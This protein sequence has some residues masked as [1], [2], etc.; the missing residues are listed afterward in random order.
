[1]EPHDF[2]AR[3]EEIKRR[4]SGRWSEL[5]RSLGVSDAILNRRNGP[6][7][8]C[9]GE[10]RFQYTD[11]FGQGDYYCRGCGHGDGF[12]LLRHVFGWDFVTAYRHV[13][14]LV[15]GQSSALVARPTEPSSDRMK[16]LARR[17]WQEA[18]P[19]KAGDEVDRYLTGRGLQFAD[20]PRTLRCH[21]ALAYYEKD[22][23]GKSRK[24]GECPAMLACIQGSDGHGIT[25]H[26]T[27]LRDGHKAFG[28]S[29]KRVL[30]AGIN[31]AAVRL[32][33]AT[34]E[35][36]ITEGIET[37]LAVH[38][39]TGKPVWSA[40]AAG[41][42]ERLWLPETVRRVCVYADND[43]D[44]DFDGQACAFALARRLKKEQKRTGA[45]QVSVFVPKVSGNDWADVWCARSRDV[46]QAA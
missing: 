37:A 10:D 33:A 15:G 32:F 16:L 11:K 14:S 30:S 41:N 25:L 8:G 5:L 46:D 6:C 35:L 19:V 17:L 45:R 24:V 21:P 7:P 26:R 20:Y 4:A 13:E 44:A 23:A 38:L 39:S 43:A 12:A 42:L 27:Y 18:E 36:A 3:V 9:G 22:G 34:D 1:M 31:G 28:R 29:S 40:I 2:K